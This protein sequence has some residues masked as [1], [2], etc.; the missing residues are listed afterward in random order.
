[1]SNQG[2]K[3]RQGILAIIGGILLIISGIHANIFDIQKLIQFAVAENFLPPFI[4]IV[5]ITILRILGFLAGIPIIIGG[6]LHMKGK[7][8]T[9]ANFL[10]TLGA[11]ISIIDLFSFMIAT[12]PAVKTYIISVKIIELSRIGLFYA[13]VLVGLALS[14]LAL[15]ADATGMILGL[16]AAFAT[17]MAGSIVEV[18]IITA[19]LAKLG[20]INPSPLVIDI[21]RMILLSGIIFLLGGYLAGTGRYKLASLVT[22]ISL[23]IY[24]IPLLVLIIGALSGHF[25]LIRLTLSILGELT[26]FVLLYHIKIS[27]Q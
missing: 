27:A 26:G 4:A 8:S 15:F 18:I 2:V 9:I 11:G 10:I 21:M 3:R 12:G 23:I 22:K 17:S 25:M 5:L 6:L 24:F 13:I 16:I 7:S 1:M 19:F 20:I 14:F